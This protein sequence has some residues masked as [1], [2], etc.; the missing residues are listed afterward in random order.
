MGGAKVQI[1][2]FSRAFS[3]DPQVHARD[4]HGHDVHAKDVHTIDVWYSQRRKAW[5]VER[6]DAEGHQ[7]GPSHSCATE[8]E[9]E[10]CLEEWLRAHTDVQLVAP[11]DA[12][13]AE[14]RLLAASQSK[15]A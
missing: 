10:A 4:A 7:V 11:R 15:A 13:A 12:S 14:R 8:S 2:G 9:A 6:L 1:I 3:D 5:M